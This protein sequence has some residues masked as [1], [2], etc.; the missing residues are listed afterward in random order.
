MCLVNFRARL[1]QR[2]Y[3]FLDV[4][5]SPHLADC[6][7]VMAGLQER[8][9]YGIKMWRFGYATQLILSVG[10]F[11]WRKFAELSL[12][13]DGG[14]VS[15]VDGIPPK[16]RHFLVRMDRQDTY[17]TPVKKGLLG[18][19]S[20]ARAVA[21]YLRNLPIRSLLVVSSPA[22]LRRTAL[23]FRRCGL[24]ATF[25][26][27]PEKISFDDVVSRSSIYREFLKYL[28]YRLLVF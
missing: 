22:H 15:M 2:I 16:K 17:C 28:F 19:R 20:E 24:Q 8:K 9:T 10:R 21:E 3:D 18:T 13:S 11:E 12:E 27:V 23:S 6:I 7:V 25:V 4:G 14:L 1:A 5:K 26:A